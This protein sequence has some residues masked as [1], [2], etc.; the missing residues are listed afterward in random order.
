MARRTIDDLLAEARQG[1]RRLT[2]LEARAALEAGAVLVDTRSDDQRRAQGFV[3]GAVS[4][5]LSV[6]HWRLDPDFPTSNPKLPLE[7]HVVLISR[8]GYSS[9]IAAAQLR[10]LGFE[11][12]TDVIDGVEGWKAAGLPLVRKADEPAPDRDE[13]V[14]GESL[15]GVAVELG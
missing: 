5:P 9:S 8:D 1:L 6:R 2:A 14:A 7:T 15:H 3:P 13:P 4:H 10:K 11:R 12:A